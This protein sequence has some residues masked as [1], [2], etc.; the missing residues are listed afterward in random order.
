MSEAILRL[1]GIEKRFGG[2]NA[3]N[4]VSFEVRKGS[5]TALI[6]PNGA[7]KTTLINLI[8]GVLRQSAGTIHLNG[9][10]ISGLSAA[11]RVMAGMSRSYQTPQMVKGLT[12]LENAA[13]GAD[14]FSSF[15]MRDLFWRPWHAFSDSARAR[16]EACRALERTGLRSE[17]WDVAADTLSYGD[18]RRVELARG[19]AQ[20]P[21]ILLLDEPAAGLNPTETEEL[22]QFLRAL[23]DEGMTILLVEHDMPLVMSTAD[24]IVVVNFGEGLA[25]GTPAEIQRNEDVIAAYLGADID[26]DFESSCNQPELR[27]VSH[28]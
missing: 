16:K 2:V 24:H 11:K 22:G 21:S 13:V 1:S 27:E 10:E 14:L 3:V 7:G 28:G 20:K 5:I 25:Q 12:A 19:L 17:L 18:Q 8:T 26:G 9:E 6:G 15:R 23:A 4:G